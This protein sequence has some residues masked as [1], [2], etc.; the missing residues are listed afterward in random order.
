VQAVIERA[1]HTHQRSG[2]LYSETQM[3]RRVEHQRRVE[4]SEAER[5]EDLNEKQR[6][7][8]LRSPGEKTLA[9]FDKL[10]RPENLAL[11]VTFNVI[12]PAVPA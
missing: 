12:C 5:R 10:R 3:L 2:L 9:S 8:S 6:S 4:D 11:R 1:E 7:R